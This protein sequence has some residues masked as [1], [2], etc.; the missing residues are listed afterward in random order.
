MQKKSGGHRRRL[1][2]RTLDQQRDACLRNA[3]GQYRADCI[4]KLDGD[5]KVGA[6][7]VSVVVPGIRF[8]DRERGFAGSHLHV[9]CRGLFSE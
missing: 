1:G 2:A 4:A 6:P 3:V 8:E 5:Q 9:Q 7:G